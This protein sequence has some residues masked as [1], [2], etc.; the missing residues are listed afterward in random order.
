MAVDVRTEIVIE[1]SRGDVAAYA[2]DPGNA[3]AWYTHIKAVERNMSKP[4]A[5]G[6]KIVFVAQFLGRRLDY[7]YEVTALEPGERFQMRTVEGP[8]PMETTYS[9]EDTG[10]GAT[11]MLLRNRGEPTGFSRVSALL[12]RR[13]MKRANRNDL[14]RLKA[15]LEATAGG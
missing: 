5:V 15:L 6:S 8:F 14:R 1:R 2:S 3:T 13:A 12:L 10:T 11:R 7:V 9:W 4:V